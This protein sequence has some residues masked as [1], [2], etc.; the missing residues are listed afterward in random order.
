MFIGVDQRLGCGEGDRCLT[1]SAR[2]DDGQQPVPF[3]QRR[4]PAHRIGAP[5]QSGQPRGQIMVSPDRRG[6]RHRRPRHLCGSDGRNKAI[7]L[8]R[9]GSD[10]APA[11][12]PIPQRPPQRADL[13]FEVALLDKGVPPRAGHQFVFANQLARTLDQSDEEIERATAEANR[14][15]AFEQQALLREQTKG[16]ERDRP[17]ARSGGV[18]GH[19]SSRLTSDKFVQLVQ[20]PLCR[21][22]V[23]SLEPFG[24][25]SKD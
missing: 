7:A 6:R 4:D 8:A 19:S 23:G 12:A 21:P 1:D 14:L 25:A 20:E 3:Y 16:S 24:E 15:V 5:D 17:V 2:P 13:E 9:G 18:I 22:E 10:V 11:A